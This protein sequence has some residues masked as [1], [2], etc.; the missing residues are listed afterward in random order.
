M[1]PLSA[2]LWLAGLWFL[3]FA[4]QGKRFRALGWAWVFT[5]GVIVTVSPRVY[6]LYPAFPLVFAAGGVMYEKWLEP[7]QRRWRRIAYPILLIAAGTI[8]TPLAVPVLP[9]ETYI[10]YA[11]A[12][13]LSPPASETHTLGPLPQNYASEYGWPEMASTVARVYNDLPPDMRAKTA[14]FAQNYGQAGAIDLFGQDYGLPRA[15]SGHQSY[16]LWGPGSYTGESMIV[17]GDSEQ[18]LEQLFANVQKVA[19]VDH[20]FSMPYQHFDVFYCRDLKQPVK[21]WW[22]QVKHWD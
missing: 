21:D 4:E 18:R 6:Y 11:R 10:R 2:P 3:F 15:I 22:P 8:L 14:I 17:M 1:N 9:I 20:P 16:F 12:L 13:H 7:R 19:R 5:A